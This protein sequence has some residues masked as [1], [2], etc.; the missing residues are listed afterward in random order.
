[1][2]DCPAGFGAD[3][4]GLCGAC[5]EG[6]SSFSGGACVD[7]PPGQFSFSGGLCMDCPAGY[8]SIGG[9][10]SCFQCAFGQ[11][12]VPGG[13][14]VNRCEAGQA[15]SYLFQQCAICPTDTFS[16]PGDTACM[17]CAEGRYA[18]KESSTCWTSGRIGGKMRVNVPFNDFYLPD[19]IHCVANVLDSETSDIIVLGTYAGS[20]IIDFEIND[21]TPDSMAGATSQI[22]HLSGNEKM[23][24]LYQWWVT[25]DERMDDFP[26]DIID[27]KEYTETVGN[28]LED[29][30][31]VQL[32]A[33]SGP[34]PSAE[35][36][37]RPPTDRPGIDS[38][39]YFDQTT[40]KLTV[41][42]D[43]GSVSFVPSLLLTFSLLLLS[44][45]FLFL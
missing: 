34:L 3:V 15:W 45:I 38:G 19:W 22:R 24:L 10:S 14:C 28:A 42:V 32:F 21:P 18:P 29:P 44:F 25:R 9:S 11:V 41:T 20:T 40:L 35:F 27:F 31:V 17:R 2:F 1:V 26:Y 8:S 5:P 43:N 36:G 33:P 13:Q 37:P 6:Q 16:L 30:E 23:L 7:C 39:F 4:G 12:S